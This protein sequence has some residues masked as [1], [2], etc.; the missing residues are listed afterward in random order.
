VSRSGSPTDFSGDSIE[1]FFAVNF[2]MDD[3]TVGFW[4]GYGDITVDSIVY[5]GAG[6]ML[7]FSEIS[8]DNEISANGVT[9]ILAGL[10]STAKDLALDQEYQYRKAEIIVGSLNNYPTI[11]SYKLFVGLID[12]VS[13]D[14]GPESST[15]SVFLEN[16]LIDLNRPRVLHYTNEEQKHFSPNRINPANSPIT[17]AT[18]VTDAGLSEIGGIQ[19][20]QIIWKAP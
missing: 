20:K 2:Q 9:V 6:E 7:S 10:D 3:E 13:I 16:R 17:G 19:D 14:D 12:K 18:I 15:V 8:E 1:L 11:Q 4:T 5:T